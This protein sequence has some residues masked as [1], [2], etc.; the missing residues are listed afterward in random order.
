MKLKQITAEQLASNTTKFLGQA[1]R[2]PLVIQSLSGPA[3]L[4]RRISDDDLAERLIVASPKFRAS[5]R[6][7]RA[8]RANGKA[9]SLK[10]A[11]E[12]L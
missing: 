1:Q 11:Q 4:I 12:M 5:I 2:S 9:I 3:L 8:N 7:A 10:K 6:R